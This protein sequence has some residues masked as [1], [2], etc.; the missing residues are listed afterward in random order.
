MVGSNFKK[1]SCWKVRREFNRVVYVIFRLKELERNNQNIEKDFIRV[2][3]SIYVNLFSY[4]LSM[5]Y[6]YFHFWLNWM[7]PELRK[8]FP[9]FITTCNQC[10][11]FSLECL[12][13]L[14]CCT[15]GAVYF[16]NGLLGLSGFMA[17]SKRK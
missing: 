5:D 7:L 4:S 10:L 11:K 8:S 13:K 2:Q 1:R 6:L 16:L 15:D 14:S 3:W 9:V 17:S 12:V